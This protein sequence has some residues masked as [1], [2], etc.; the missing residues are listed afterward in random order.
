MILLDP[1]GTL[2]FNVGIDVFSAIVTVILYCSYKNDFTNTCD[3]LMMRRIEM[4]VLLVLLTD[5]VMW[6]I[7]GKQGVLMRILGYVDNMVY[8]V[9][10]FAVVL[11]WLRYSWY[12]ISGQNMTRKRDLL[13]VQ[14][15]FLLLSL[16]IM[17]SPLTGWCFYLDDLNY[18][19][20]GILST[21]IFVIVLGY[22]LAAAA[23]ALRQYGKEVNVDRKR[24]LLT[25]AFFAVPP[26]FGGAVQIVIYGCS[27]VWPCVV[28]SC[29]L[30]LLTRESQAISQD[31]LTGLNNRRSMEK[32]LRAYSDGV[33]TGVALVIMDIN[34]F[35]QINDLHGHDTGDEALIQVAEILRVTFN[36]TSAFLARYG[37]DEFVIILPI[38]EEG[39]AA[40][41]VRRVKER[42]D[43]FNTTRQFPFRLTASI[44]W[45]ISLGKADQR[46]SNLLR[47][48]DADMYREKSKYHMSSQK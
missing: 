26:L 3:N 38:G 14:I 44:G 47:E 19:H 8:F 17:I 16:C 37:G 25:I 43:A 4:F 30:V 41:A 15:P 21:P 34:D 20:R 45:A 36:G 27:L 10:E 7:N 12:R 32:Y 40:E 11:A 24:E 9:M 29:L 5:T 33:Q 31:S 46:I 39:E 6:V 2:L 35:K 13:F 1:Q 28:I 42:F 23:V 48:A 22:L 18:Y